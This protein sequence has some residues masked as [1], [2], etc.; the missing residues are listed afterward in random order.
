MPDLPRLKPVPLPDIH[1][2]P[3]YA[4]DAR[5]HTVYE[6]TRQGLGVPWMGS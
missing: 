2:V 1:P 5:L 4:A 3:E 6:R